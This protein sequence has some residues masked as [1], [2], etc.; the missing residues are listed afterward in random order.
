MAETNCSTCG[1]SGMVGGSGPCQD[2]GGTG[3][4]QVSP[5]QRLP[6]T[7]CGGS[8]EPF[9]IGSGI[10]PGV[11]CMDCAGTGKVSAWVPE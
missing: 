1:G 8:V 7:S 3:W 5:V 11:I 2:C 9:V 4:K 6:C 10:S